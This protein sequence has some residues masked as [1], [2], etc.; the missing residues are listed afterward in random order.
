[1][2]LVR[3]FNEPEGRRYLGGG[4]DA[5]RDVDEFVAEA[6]D[7]RKGL[8]YD[9]RSRCKGIG[10]GQSTMDVSCHLLHL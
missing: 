3:L 7:R 9:A 5:S 10:Y 2:S 6:I 8:G 1:V 4:R